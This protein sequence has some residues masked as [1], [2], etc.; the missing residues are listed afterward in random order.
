M[1][2]E[3]YGPDATRRQAIAADVKALFE[4]TP[5]VVD[6]DWYVEA[7]Q[8]KTRLVVD[9]EKAMAAGLSAADV[10]AVVRMAGDGAVAGLLHVP[11]AREDVPIVLRLP[12]DARGL[13][14]IQSVRLGGATPVAV[15][16]LTRVVETREDTS[17]YHKN[18]QAG[19]LRDRRPRR[20]QREPR[21]R[22]PHDERD[23]Q[24]DDAAR[25]VRS[26]GAERRAALR[27]VEVRDEV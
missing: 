16:A 5:G 24:H 13:E 2:A 21:L 18:L 27:H 22:H 26:R 15:G 20:R 10:A 23:A 14:A 4:R 6:T 8:P 12:R 9:G 7:G 11:T 1:V 17:R 25:R 19:H 3:I